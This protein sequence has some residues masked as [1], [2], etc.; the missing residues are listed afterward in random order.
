MA[1]HRRVFLKSLAAGLGSSLIPRGAHA[2]PRRYALGLQF[3]PGADFG[4]LAKSQGRNGPLPEAASVKSLT[5]LVGNQGQQGSCVGWSV[6][7]GLASCL[8]KRR[9][10]SIQTSPSFIYDRGHLIDSYA[11]GWKS[12]CDSGMFIETALSYLQGFG[13]LALNEFPYV[14]ATCNRLPNVN[15]DKAARRMRVVAD[16]SVAEDIKAV[17]SAIVAGL[18]ALIG[19]AVREPLFRLPPGGIYQPGT[20]SPVQGGHAMLVVGYDD[21]R[22]AIQVMNSWGTGWAD[23]GFGWIAYNAVERDARVDGELRMYTVLP[24]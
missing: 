4:K 20:A 7:Y 21:N 17:K 10:I 12:G 8:M 22:Q 1:L 23:S 16:W 19:L 2:Q 9:G 14:D 6:G 13:I 11:N 24:S 5:P 3:L 18:P 15:E